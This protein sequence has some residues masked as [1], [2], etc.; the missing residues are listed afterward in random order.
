MPI[1]PA[2]AGDELGVATVH[3][4]SWQA[5]YRGLL[6][7]DFL[8]GL[9]PEDRAAQYNFTSGR[10]RPIV[11]V[12]EDSVRGF[13]AFGPSRDSDNEGEL[14][15]IYVHPDHWGGG[16]GRALITE[17]RRLLAQHYRSAIL[18][19]LIGNDQAHRFYLADG[20]TEEKTTR[21]EQMFGATVNETRF[22]RTLP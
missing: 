19:V 8:D 17:A 14:Y 9:R 11:A 4:R 5:A 20:W 12:D 21:T 2:A 16:H 13:A 3:V 22:R 1:R 6:P 18:W 7:D 10:T 15:A